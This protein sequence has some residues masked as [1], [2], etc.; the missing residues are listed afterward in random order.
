MASSGV[1]A[2]RMIGLAVCGCANDALMLLTAPPPMSASPL[3]DYRFALSQVAAVDV[4]RESIGVADSPSPKAHFTQT[5]DG[6]RIAY[7]IHGQGPCLVYVR[8]LNSH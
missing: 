4:R 8:A 6:V 1:G 7:T 5:Q 2:S 3:A